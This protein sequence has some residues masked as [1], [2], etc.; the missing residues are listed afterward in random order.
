MM[1]QTLVGIVLDRSDYKEYDALL[2]VFTKEHGVI[3]WIAKGVNKPK[4]KYNGLLQPFVE[5]EALV[6]VK[7]G[8]SLFKSATSLGINSH[9]SESL[10]VLAMASFLSKILGGN[11]SVDG[12]LLKFEEYKAYLQ[13]INKI[14]YFDVGTHFLMRL[15]KDMGMELYL[16]GCVICQNPKI[17]GVS[18]SAGGFL[19]QSHLASNHYQLF[20]KEFLKQ[21]RCLSKANLEQV[22]QCTGTT[23]LEHM[24]LYVSLLSDTLKIPMKNW[25]FISQL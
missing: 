22:A 20:D 3:T 1:N 16:D 19:C 15:A 11:A 17:V 6:D 8:I 13:I 24:Q 9:L 14:N 12:N 10:E 21:L 7:P 18:I 4:S 23:Q 25:R 2:R 5:L